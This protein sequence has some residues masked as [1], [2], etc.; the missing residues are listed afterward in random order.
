MNADFLRAATDALRLAGILHFSVEEIAPVGRRPYPTGPELTPPSPSQLAVAIE[1]ARVLE[2]LRAQLGRPIVVTSWYRDPLYNHAV[3]GAR[4]SLHTTGSAADI[5][6]ASVAP[7]EVR[8]TLER[9]PLAPQMGIGVYPSFTHV[10]LRG[11]LG[12]AAPARW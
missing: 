3:G 12:R 2:W 8:R 11:T 10:D 6:V 5:K 4:N 1:T 9:H 7:V